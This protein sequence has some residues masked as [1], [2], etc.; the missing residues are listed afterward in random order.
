MKEQWC[1]G[2]AALLLFVVWVCESILWQYTHHLLVL[3]VFPVLFSLIY[4]PIV[5]FLGMAWHFS[6]TYPLY[7]FF[8]GI[9]VLFFLIYPPVAGFLGVAW[10]FSSTYPHFGFFLGI[11]CPFLSYIPT[12]CRLLGC[13]VA[14]FFYI[15]S[16]WLLLGYFLSFSL[17]YTHRLPASW[18]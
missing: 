4:P 18:V 13:S 2:T 3:W 1:Q 8:L 10:H 17:L 6:S 15:P 7:G 12:A 5:D 11:S 14:L 9:S 16:L